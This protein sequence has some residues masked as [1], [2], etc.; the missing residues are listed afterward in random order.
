MKLEFSRQIFEKYLN[1]KFHENP[2]SCCR[3]IPCGRT[4]G[5]ICNF[6]NKPKNC[7]AWNF[8]LRPPYYCKQSQISFGQEW[9]ADST[10]RVTLA[11]N[12]YRIKD[13]NH[14]SYLATSDSRL[15]HSAVIGSPAGW[16]LCMC[17]SART[18]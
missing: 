13:G 11:A 15:S 3:V 10:R 6:T 8:T 1:I 16:Q 9:V 2:S 7:T 17:K 12:A 14:R 5:W 4:E 18:N